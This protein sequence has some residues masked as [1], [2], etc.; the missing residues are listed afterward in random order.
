MSE[1]KFQI[2][3]DGE[4]VVNGAGDVRLLTSAL[5]SLGD[6][7]NTSNQILNG[8]LATTSLRV[9]S[10]FWAGSFEVSLF[11]NRTLLEKT[12]SLFG[13]NET[14]DAAGLVTAIVG[15]PRSASGVIQGLLKAYKALHGEKPRTTLTDQSNHTSI[16]VMGDGNEV[17][18]EHQTAKLYSDGR[19]LETVDKILQPLTSNGIDKFEVKHEDETIDRLERE[20]LPIRVRYCK[21]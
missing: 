14:V 19:V 6:L 5:L 3:Y 18:V 21:C 9:E 7:V 17:Q 1:A 12:R 11:L 15:I 13:R 2:A 16:F 20:D 8:D 4:S 10:N